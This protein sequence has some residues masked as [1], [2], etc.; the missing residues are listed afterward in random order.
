LRSFF[1]LCLNFFRLCLSIVIAALA[2]WAP[3]PKEGWRW[4]MI[5]DLCRGGGNS[6]ALEV[7]PVPARVWEITRVRRSPHPGARRRKRSYIVP[8][9]RSRT[10]KDPCDRDI[11]QSFGGQITDG[12][13]RSGIGQ[14]REL[15]IQDLVSV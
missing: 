12:I 8:V 6:W 3:S 15:M 11:Y 10:G 1:V 5:P 14:H 2:L 4:Q 13:A 9:F 7:S